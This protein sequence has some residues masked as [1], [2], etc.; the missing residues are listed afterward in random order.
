MTFILGLSETN[1]DLGAFDVKKGDIVYIQD[2]NMF[3]RVENESYYGNFFV[4][5]FVPAELRQKFNYKKDDYKKFFTIDVNKLLLVPNG[6]IKAFIKDN[7][8][9]DLDDKEELNQSC[10]LQKFQAKSWFE[11]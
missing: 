10:I 5:P 6:D 7:P 11:N 8:D 4:H 9:L 2:N 1:D 3:A